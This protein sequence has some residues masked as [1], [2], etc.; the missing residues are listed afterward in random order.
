MKICYLDCF[1]GIAGDM[2]LGALVDAGLDPVVLR[3]TVASLKLKGVKVRTEKTKRG[4]LQATQVFVETEGDHPHRSLSAIEKII[5]DSTLTQK[6]KQNSL[7]VFRRLGTVEAQ[8]HGVPVEKVHFHEVGAWD[9]ITDIV[10]ACAGFDAMDIQR[11]QCSPINLGSGTVKAA[12]GVMPVPA[13]ATA[14]LVEGI[15]TY[16]EG[17]QA[18]LTTPTGAALATTL[19]DSFGAM[20]AM[21]LS[22]SGYGAGSGDFPERAN[23]LRVLIGEIDDNAST[24]DN[25]WVLEANIDDMTPE[26]AGYAM[27]RLLAAGALDVTLTPVHMKKNRPGF[28]LTVLASPDMRT[29]LSRLIFSETTTLGIRETSAQR[30]V[31]ERHWQEVSTTYGKVRIKVSGEN[32]K[33][34]NH[35]PEYEDCRQLAQDNNVPFKEIWQQ[36]NQEF[37]RNQDN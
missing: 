7:R 27:E 23:L 2:L 9:A 1:C 16:V 20:P 19:S 36:A 18:E 21:Q 4:G 31:L 14:R 6:V 32:G 12:H 33:T 8:A 30:R 29:S 17:P 26:A 28:T 25:I 13:P 11:I 34:F 10:G 22:A 3:N 15:P 37:L 24:T 5:E 35:A